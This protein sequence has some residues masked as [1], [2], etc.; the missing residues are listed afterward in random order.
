MLDIL[1]IRMQYHDYECGLCGAPVDGP[2]GWCL[3][4]AGMGGG[5]SVCLAC[6]DARPSGEVS[7]GELYALP[8]PRR[9]NHA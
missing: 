6:H 1:E 4:V 8:T 2:G 3:L 7:T 5:I 9:A